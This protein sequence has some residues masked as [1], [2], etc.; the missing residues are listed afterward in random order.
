MVK[1]LKYLGYPIYM[2]DKRYC[3]PIKLFVSNLISESESEGMID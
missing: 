3:I 2:V 1:L